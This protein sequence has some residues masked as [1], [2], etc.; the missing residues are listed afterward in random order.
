MWM[1]RTWARIF[2]AR[3]YTHSSTPTGISPP[4][5]PVAGGE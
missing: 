3:V 2:T 5:S 1:L 4:Y